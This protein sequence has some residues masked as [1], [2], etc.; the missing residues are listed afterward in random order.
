MALQQRIKDALDEGRMVVL[1]VQVLLGFQFRV[2][3][4]HRFDHLPQAVR[5]VHL[6]GLALLLAAFIL[7]VAPATFRGKTLPAASSSRPSRPMERSTC[8]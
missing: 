2:V 7:A 8:S 3:L 5:L 6:G 1:V 4:E